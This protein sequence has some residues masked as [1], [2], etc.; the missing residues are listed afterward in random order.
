[1][2]NTEDFKNK[3]LLNVNELRFY[4]GMGVCN[5]VKWAKGI[6]AERRIGRRL[7]FDKWVIDKAISNQANNESES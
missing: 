2:D 5:A 6:G 3:R 4:L 7:L 1:M